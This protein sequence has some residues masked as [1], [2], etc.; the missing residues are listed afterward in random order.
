MSLC[1]SSS[2]PVSVVSLN[3][4]L[5]TKFDKMLKCELKFEDEHVVT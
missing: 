3:S 2:C 5:Y 1:L 4:K